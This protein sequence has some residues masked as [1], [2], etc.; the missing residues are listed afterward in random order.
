MIVTEGVRG[1]NIHHV[2]CVKEK[3][4]VD[5]RL[6]CQLLRAVELFQIGA[7]IFTELCIVL[8]QLDYSVTDIVNIG[9]LDRLPKER[10]WLFKE[11]ADLT[12]WFEG[13]KCKEKAEPDCKN[14]QYC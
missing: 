13:L 12:H 3:V 6:Q 4:R 11:P 8:H 1:L 5:L 10:I 9:T 2:E 14:K 7:K